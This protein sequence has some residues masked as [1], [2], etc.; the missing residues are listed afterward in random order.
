MVDAADLSNGVEESQN[1]YLLLLCGFVD[2]LN[3]K[4]MK[5]DGNFFNID[6]EAGFEASNYRFGI[7]I[8]GKWVILGV[9]WYVA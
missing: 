8:E 2:R 1:A 3:E 7:H 4:A 6:A 5:S 9:L